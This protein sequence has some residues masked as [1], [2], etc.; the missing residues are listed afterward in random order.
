MV[1]IRWLD[2]GTLLVRYASGS[3]IFQQSRQVSGVSINYQ[4]GEP[5]YGHRIEDQE[6]QRQRPRIVAAR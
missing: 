6:L 3:R 2:H 1:D 4:A 5:R